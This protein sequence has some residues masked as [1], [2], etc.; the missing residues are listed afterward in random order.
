MRDFLSEVGG[1]FTSV[2]GI[3][4]FFISG[5]QSF[6]SEKSMIKKLYGEVR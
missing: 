4:T 3:F 6:V 1:F 2:M 5:Y